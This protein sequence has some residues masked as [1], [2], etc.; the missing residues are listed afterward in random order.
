MT[1]TIGERH[2]LRRSN[3]KIMNKKEFSQSLLSS[4]PQSFN[5][6][7]LTFN[8]NPFSIK[9]SLLPCLKQAPPPNFEPITDFRL[10]THPSIPPAS[11][12]T[13]HCHLTSN[14]QLDTLN[15]SFNLVRLWRNQAPPPHFEPIASQ[16]S[17]LPLDLPSNL[18]MTIPPDPSSIPPF[19]MLLI[20]SE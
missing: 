13:H 14:H 8:Q 15:S 10:Q 9:S 1:T 3:A 16:S 18:F 5:I 7:L 2:W 4:L 19:P 12:Q 20:L 6:L 11:K 17:T